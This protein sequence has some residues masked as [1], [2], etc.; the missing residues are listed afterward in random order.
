MKLNWQ[1]AMAILALALT[2]ALVPLPAIASANGAR[3]A[4]VVSVALSYLGRPY[5]FGATGPRTFD[6]SGFTRY[7]MNRAVGI[8]LPRTAASQSRVGRRIDRTTLQQGD[9]VFFQ[10]T[11][12]PGV[13]H[14]GIALGNG[15]M[16]HAW[17]RG[18]VRIDR[19]SQAYFVA[20]YHSSRTVLR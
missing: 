12:K 4:R 6:C 16:V 7:V 8:R 1:K 3:G 14:V 20:K 2:V 13:S 17:T 18:G 10:N 5:V 9:L 15:R 11:Y 19:L